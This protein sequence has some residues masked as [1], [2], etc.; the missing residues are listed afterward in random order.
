M[1]NE[2][3]VG[4]KYKLTKRLG[5]GAFGTLYAGVNMK[6]NEEVALKLEKLDTNHPTLHYESKIYK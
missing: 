6:T 5:Q 2:L 1:S 4:S 3:L